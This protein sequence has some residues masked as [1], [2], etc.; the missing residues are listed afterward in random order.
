[1]MT[2][3]LRSGHEVGGNQEKVRVQE[4][5]F[6]EVRPLGKMLWVGQVNRH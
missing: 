2:R 6:H 5:V 3:V 4:L 1:M